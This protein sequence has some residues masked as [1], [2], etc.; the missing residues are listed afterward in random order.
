MEN[1]MKPRKISPNLKKAVHKDRVKSNV[2]IDR[3]YPTTG[4][5]TI[6]DP[7]VVD[8]RD[9]S[10]DDFPEVVANQVRRLCLK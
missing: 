3:E 9:V 2:S 8:I 1:L 10:I 6:D 5:G 4:S 7:Y